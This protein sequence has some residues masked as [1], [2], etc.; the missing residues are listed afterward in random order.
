[1]LMKLLERLT[2]YNVPQLNRV[3]LQL[4]RFVAE[5]AQNLDSLVRTKNLSLLIEIPEDVAVQA[6]PF[7]LKQLFLNL[8]RMQ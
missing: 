1:M 5:V 2:I 4:R 8:L 7:H 6:D 3:D